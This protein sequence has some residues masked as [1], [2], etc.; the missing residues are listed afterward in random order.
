MSRLGSIVS[1]AVPFAAAMVG[2]A[3]LGSGPQPLGWSL[4]TAL[5]VVVT[6]LFRV[7]GRSGMRLTLAMA[8]MAALPIVRPPTSETFLGDVA[9][10]V[11]PIAV[12]VVVVWVYRTTR[13]EDPHQV[14]VDTVRRVAGSAAYLVI[15]PVTRFELGSWVGGYGDL[16]AIVAAMIAAFSIEILVGLTFRFRPRLESRSAIVRRELSDLAAYLTLV[17][18]GAWGGYVFLQFGPWVVPVGAMLYLFADRAFRRLADARQTYDQT[19]RALARIPEVADQV[20]EGHADRTAALVSNVAQRYRIGPDEVELIVRAAYL[21]DIG[22]ISMNDP[23][24]AGLGATDAEIAGWGAEIVREAAL[25]REAEL[26]ARQCEV[27][28]HPGQSAVTDVPLGARI[29]K[30]CSA[31]DQGVHELGM[32]PL[33]SMERLH[34]GSVY[35]YDPE[36]VDRLRAVLEAHD[37]FTP[38]P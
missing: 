17:S 16:V 15:F 32:S 34:R 26:I 12:G 23:G 9:G 24:V 27:F 11:A 19:I 37:G 7:P 2:A 28:R 18:I 13:N 22:R 6:E 3:L 1:I 14:L 10:L 25:D 20:A 35:D 30:V 21:H 29:I 33:E 36:V 4:L 31:Y 38:S 5:L 8:V